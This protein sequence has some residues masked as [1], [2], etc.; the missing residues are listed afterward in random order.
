[1]KTKISV[2]SVSSAWQIYWAE[3]MKEKKYSRSSV[4][5]WFGVNEFNQLNPHLTCTLLKQFQCMRVILLH[6]ITTIYGILYN[7][8]QF[9]T[10]LK[11][12][13][14]SMDVQC[15]KMIQVIVRLGQCKCRCW[16]L[17][18]MNCLNTSNTYIRT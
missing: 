4:D 11:C 17:H 5:R 2:S 18:N 16:C 1:M 6:K 9:S 13:R 10:K 3:A 8:N 7:K 14:D 15:K 12:E